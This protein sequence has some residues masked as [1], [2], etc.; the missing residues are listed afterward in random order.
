MPTLMYLPNLTPLTE[1]QELLPAAYN[2]LLALCDARFPPYP[3][4][5]NNE[6]STALTSPNEKEREKFKENETSRLK[7][8]DRIARKGIFA[9]FAHSR[10]HPEIVQLLMDHLKILIDKMGLNAV[11]HLKDILPL[12]ASPL[13]DPFAT[14]RPALLLSA[15]HCLQSMILCAWPRVVGEDRYRIEVLRVL[16]LGWRN[17]GMDGKGGLEAVK[18]QMRITGRMMVSAGARGDIE[19]LVRGVEGEGLDEL[20]GIEV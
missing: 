3:S 20:F 13:T 9:G 12:L 10:E 4:G 16:V 5:T 2:A 14:A 17:A 1:S 6:K 11:K 7:F 18:K 8:L 15:L 19:M